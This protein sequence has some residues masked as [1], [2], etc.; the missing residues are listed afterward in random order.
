M[1]FPSFIKQVHLQAPQKLLSQHNVLRRDH[2]LTTS[3]VNTAGS[4]SFM[5]YETVTEIREMYS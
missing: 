3:L 1:R 2:C 5:E 4:Y